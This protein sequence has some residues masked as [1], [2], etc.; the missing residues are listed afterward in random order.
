[1]SSVKKML[2]VMVV[3][4]PAMVAQAAM[5]IP[6]PPDWWQVPPDPWTRRNF[7]HSR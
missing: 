1:M 6:P 4:M 2:F 5:T 7:P 3:C